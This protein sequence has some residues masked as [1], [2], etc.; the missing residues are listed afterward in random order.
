MSCICDHPYIVVDP[1]PNPCE[2]CLYV[3]SHVTACEDS[4]GPCAASDTIQLTTNCDTPA[5]SVVFA[6]PAFTSVSIS[7]GGLL[8]FTTVEGEAT[9]DTYYTII[10]KV[11][12]SSEDF[13]GLGVIGTAGICIKNLCSGVTCAGGEVCDPCDGTCGPAEINLQLNIA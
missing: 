9:P 11:T 2:D 1:P 5:Y 13:S 6:D 3:T 8:S 12:C 4:V 10:Y 7:V